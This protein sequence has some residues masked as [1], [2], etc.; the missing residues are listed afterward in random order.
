MRLFKRGIISFI[1]IVIVLT[2]CKK[3]EKESTSDEVLLPSG[4]EVIT[5][6]PTQT[7]TPS[8]TKTSVPT[9][10]PSPTQTP[11]PTKIVIPA[12]TLFTFEVQPINIPQDMKV[13]Y[14]S[15][16]EFPRLDGS[17]ANIPLGEALYCYITNAT[18]EEAKK[19]LKFYKTTEA[20]QNLMDE[21]SDIL[22]VYEP[23][24]S[25][26]KKMHDYNVEFEFKPLGRDALVFLGNESNSVSNLTKGQIMDIYTGA[27]RNWKKL[28]GIDKE[29]LAFQ[30][31]ESSGSQTLMEK[32]AVPSDRIMRGPTVVSPE[33]MGAL[34]DAIAQYN[35]ESNAIG[36]SVYY[37]ANYMY[38][39]PGLKFF[40]IDGIAP[41]NETIQSGEYPYV[42]DFYVVI[43]KSEPKDSKA[44]LLYEWLTSIDA[45]KLVAGAGYVP[46][47]NVE[48]QKLELAI[49]TIEPKSI[50]IKE[51]EYVIIHNLN[52]QQEPL[53]DVLLSRNLKEELIFSGKRILKDA[54]LLCNKNDLLI[55]ESIK[56]QL[57]LKDV[58]S[59][60]QYELYDLESMKYLTS[61]KYDTLYQLNSDIY[62]ARAWGE[63]GIL[64]FLFSKKKRLDFQ[65]KNNQYYQYAVSKNRLFVY[66]NH[67]IVLYDNQGKLIKTIPFSNNNYLD[68]GYLQKIEGVE[69]SNYVQI[70]YERNIMYL[71]N[72][73]G[74]L[75]KADTFL[76]NTK[77]K[78]QDGVITNVF[79]DE[80]GILWA[81]IYVDDNLLVVSLSGIVQFQF[82]AIRGSSGII[83]CPGYINFYNKESDSYK[84]YY[85]T[86]DGEKI[87]GKAGEEFASINYN[88]LVCRQD[89]FTMYNEK[90]KEHYDIKVKNYDRNQ[91]CG[92]E[93]YT[94]PNLIFFETEGKNGER[95]EYTYY[96]DKLLLNKGASA[97]REL[98]DYIIIRDSDY[99]YVFTKA[100]KKVY[101]S[102]KDEMIRDLI[103]GEQLYV[104]V[105]QGNYR[106]IKD[107]RGNFLYRTYSPNLDD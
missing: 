11:S 51:D 84:D 49:D 45:Q 50:S 60:Y 14:M 34:V 91:F 43:R 54:N 4:T 15:K 104:Y 67:E 101:K 56:P 105:E 26:L 76:K 46:V 39:K 81:A 63:E 42:N 85:Y 88:L 21:F 68:E 29:I 48:Q 83:F 17:T 73:Q 23:P 55:L 71:I 87:G 18:K 35:N 97:I 78:S 9:K 93:G 6:Q 27:I 95:K 36:Y 61:R 77:W 70:Y 102:E 32:L 90:Q 8:P 99:S 33:E 5:N 1:L 37:Y 75:I 69:L 58:I 103:L 62:V 80:K 86:W 74:D 41:T 96:G 82:K 79:F 53:G 47:V 7:V 92:R 2:A 44:R 31:P 94:F 52:G 65:E 72:E 64:S 24:Q 66:D 28:G 19:D 38:Q 3:K 16:E 20:Y 57:G 22:L 98:K 107:M 30:R 40:T 106:G 13:P 89:G 25:I 12:E 10:P 59:Q 100:G